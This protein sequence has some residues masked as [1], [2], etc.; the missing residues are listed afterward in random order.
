MP[1]PPTTAPAPPPAAAAAP[2]ATPAKPRGAL[3]SK[4]T[5]CSCSWSDICSS[6]AGGGA[7][8]WRCHDWARHHLRHRP[9]AQVPCVA[10]NTPGGLGRP[11]RSSTSGNPH[12]GSSGG[13]AAVSYLEGAGRFLE[14]QQPTRGRGRC[15]SGQQ[16]LTAASAACRPGAAGAWKSFAPLRGFLAFPCCCAIEEAARL[17]SACCNSHV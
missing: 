13:Q 8:E 17:D 3:T 14:H 5:S 16:F 7:A 10:T 6:S 4:C 9:G 15:S 11:K 12:A 1:L 2:T